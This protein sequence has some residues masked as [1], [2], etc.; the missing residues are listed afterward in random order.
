M[1]VG[2]IIG[3]SREGRFGEQIGK[4]VHELAS[5]REGEVS[6]ELLDL[7]AFNVPLLTSPTHPMM[8][9]KNYSDAQVQ[10]WSDAIDACDAYVFV[11]PEYNHAVPGALKNAVDSLG[12]EWVGKPVGFIGYGAVGGV[13]AIE[14]WRQI[15][16]NFSMIGVRAE[17]N[18]STFTDF[19]DK[20][21]APAERRAGEVNEVFN[22]VEQIAARLAD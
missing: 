6:Y 20:T 17:V 2:I 4:W 14:N 16:A 11:T 5:Q 13:R 18:I 10:A 19:E 15:V 21:F 12:A 1:Q 9:K 8:A 7:K 3:S 22:Q